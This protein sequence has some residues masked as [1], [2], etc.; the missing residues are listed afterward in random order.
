MNPDTA[1]RRRE[2]ERYRR[3]P[4]ILQRNLDAAAKSTMTLRDDP[5]CGQVWRELKRLNHRI[6][7]LRRAINEDRWPAK[8]MKELLQLLP[9]RE[10][11]RAAYRQV[12]PFDALGRRTRVSGGVMRLRP[13]VTDE[14]VDRQALAALRAEGWR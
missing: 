1:R 11:A 5:L 13:R 6:F 2:R 9:E 7:R 8:A 14:D 10:Q 12:R 4:V 3:D